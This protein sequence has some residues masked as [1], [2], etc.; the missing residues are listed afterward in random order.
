MTATVRIRTLPTPVAAMESAV[1]A[2][3]RSL[4]AAV[5]MLRSEIGS[6]DPGAWASVVSDVG[7]ASRSLR[8]RWFHLD[9]RSP[10]RS[11]ADEIVT[12]L[13]SAVSA[14]P[15]EAVPH[16]VVREI[17]Q[18]SRA[19]ASRSAAMI[20]RDARSRLGI[21]LR[22]AARRAG[23][24]PGH[25]SELEDGGRNL[26]TLSTAR[27]LDL[28][29]SIN[30]ADLVTAIREAPPMPRP[31]RQ[32]TRG[33][34][35]TPSGTSMSIDPALDTLLSRIAADERLVQLNQDLLSLPS[36]ARRGLA[37]MIRAVVSDV[38]RSSH[39]DNR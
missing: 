23:T 24:A 32:R 1:D 27:K 18:W 28:A 7:E 9:P 39:G 3:R 12:L 36:A 30:L 2:G 4:Y 6:G 33:V 26:P 34:A 11:I 38:T 14:I 13:T 15:P 21:T 10:F 22:E 19:A 20:I 17:A 37:Q 35:A 29:L 25:L 16:S 5:D 31:S 8:E